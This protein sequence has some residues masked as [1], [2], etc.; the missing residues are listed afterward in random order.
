[1]LRRGSGHLVA[2]SSLAAFKGLP[3]ESAYCAS[4]AAVN[5]YLEGL[6]I[7]L[8][9]H[10]IRVTIACPGFVETPMTAVNEF[11]MPFVMSAEKAADHI[12]WA[13]RKRKKV[14]RFPRR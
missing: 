12:L 4:K 13:I 5:A 3:G 7:Q 6:R 11:P 2:I 10:G 9:D 1:M 14:Y 8:R